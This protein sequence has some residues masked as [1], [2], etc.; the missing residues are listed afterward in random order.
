MPFPRTLLQ[1]TLS[2]ALLSSLFVA[3]IT[4]P[5]TAQDND[6]QWRHAGAL[7]GT[8]KY[9]EGF[10]HFDYVNPDAPKGGRAVLGAVGSFDTFN[11]VLPK[12]E[13]APGTN[14]AAATLIYE[15]LLKPSMDE[16]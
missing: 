13:S 4:E 16:A 12:G 3:A 8:P 9:P 2:V 5:A 6:K 7:N 14:V 1:L 11:P 10:P 15:T